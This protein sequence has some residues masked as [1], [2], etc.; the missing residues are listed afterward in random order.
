[1]GDQRISHPRKETGQAG[2]ATWTGQSSIPCP[3]G[4]KAGGEG[5]PN[6]HIRRYDWETGGATSKRD[7]NNGDPRQPHIN[8]H[9][10]TLTTLTPHLRQA[11][12]D[13]KDMTAR[14]R[15]KAASL[16]PQSK[17]ITTTKPMIH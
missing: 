15:T 13:G 11:A 7:A 12:D 1:M 16:L 5:A 2:M 14:S 9:N 17:H 3:R 6:H 8:N 4:L 10:N